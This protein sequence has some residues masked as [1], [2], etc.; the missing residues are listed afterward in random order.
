[1]S[2]L[3][4]CNGGRLLSGRNGKSCSYGTFRSPF[5]ADEG[6]VGADVNRA[7]RIAACGHGGQ[8][9]VSASTAWL[10]APTACGTWASTG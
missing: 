10:V 8:V 7:T 9:L 4:R 3:R 1:M 2:G 6:Y 5:L